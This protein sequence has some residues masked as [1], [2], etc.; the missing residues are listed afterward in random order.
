MK[1]K[2]VMAGI[3]LL[4]LGMGGCV[5]REPQSASKTVETEALLDKLIRLPEKGFMFGHQDDPVWH[6]VGWRREP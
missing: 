3:F 1:N 5:T 6:P 4:A 2:L